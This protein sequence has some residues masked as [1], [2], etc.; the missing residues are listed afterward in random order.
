MM[1]VA[2]SSSCHD[3]KDVPVYH[4]EPCVFF[5]TCIHHRGP[6][7]KATGMGHPSNVQHWAL[8]IQCLG[9]NL[10][11]SNTTQV[12]RIIATLYYTVL[13]RWWEGG[14][15]Y[16]LL[17]RTAHIIIFSGRMRWPRQDRYHRNQDPR[18]C[19]QL[20]D[21]VHRQTTFIHR[22]ESRAHWTWG[23]RLIVQCSDMIYGRGGAGAFYATCLETHAYGWMTILTVCSASHRNIPAAPNGVT[24][25]RIMGGFSC[26]TWEISF[27]FV[28]LPFFFFFLPRKKQAGTCSEIL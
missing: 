13:K 28:L 3:L 1:V 22:F 12:D 6:N 10:K 11:P 19:R 16:N 23:F 17:I 27:W 8:L 24:K 9:S 20:T 18:M 5:L 2:M 25:G 26:Q 14:E 15:L 7:N 21:R 4:P